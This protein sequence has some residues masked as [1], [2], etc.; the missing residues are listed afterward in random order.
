V[1][2]VDTPRR[3]ARATSVCDAN[4]SV[5]ARRSTAKRSWTSA[6]FVFALGALCVFGGV[7]RG[8]SFARAIITDGDDD[9]DTMIRAIARSED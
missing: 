2:R 3:P 5:M 1:T 9:L 6:L 8:T 7:A 4:R